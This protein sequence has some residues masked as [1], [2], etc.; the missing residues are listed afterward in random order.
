MSKPQRMTPCLWKLEYNKI[1]HRGNVI[2][3][4][5]FL[6][7]I[8]ILILFTNDVIDAPEGHQGIND[9]LPKGLKS[10]PTQFSR[11]SY[12]EQ[13]PIMHLFD[14]MHIGKN[15]TNTL[16]KILDGR[17]D[18]EK[19]VKICSGIEESN[20]AIKNFIRSNKNQD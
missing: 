19:I 20:H 14:S 11:L 15:V 12:Y 17:H 3:S 7:E 4:D 5:G 2:P 6:F 18:K 1:N 13:L 8:H 9:Q 10:Y 16:W